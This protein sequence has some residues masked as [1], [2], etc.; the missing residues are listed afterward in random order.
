MS[1][2]GMIGRG[3][4]YGSD[5]DSLAVPDPLFAI[6]YQ[7]E[8]LAITIANCSYF[9]DMVGATDSV[10]ARRHIYIH[11]LP[12]PIDGDRYSQQELMA[13]RP[14]ALIATDPFHGY[15][16]WHDAAYSPGDDSGALII[17]FE[18]NSD[19]DIL[20]DD[21]AIMRRWTN[22]I[23]GIVKANPPE[24]YGLMDLAHTRPDEDRDYLAIERVNVVQ[25]YR[26]DEP[27]TVIAQGDHLFAVLQIRWGGGR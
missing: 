5:F 15:A 18:K 3:F 13:Y 25:M 12:R 1:L 27:K 17:N 4:G 24:T 20:N 7:E 14:F 26:V 16:R 9:Q 22:W 23:G 6:S 2:C 10:E 8:R 11:T 21:Q 19:R